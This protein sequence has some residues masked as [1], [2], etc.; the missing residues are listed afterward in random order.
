MQQLTER[1]SEARL[2]LAPGRASRLAGRT[3]LWAFLLA[4][5]GAVLFPV[6]VALLGSF[7]TNA[8]LIAGGTFLPSEWQFANY[9][10]AWREANFARYT[11]NSLFV[12]AAT[13]ALTL[14]I[15]SMAA[16]AIDRLH[17]PGKKWFVAIQGFTMFV[18]IGAVVLR[19]QFE[20]MVSMKLHTSLWGVVFILVSAHASL[21]FIL[22]SYMKSIPR[23]LDEAATIDGAGFWRTYRSVILPLLLPGLGVAGLFTFRAA[24]NEFILPQVFTMNAPQLQTLTVG[25]AALRYG[26]SAAMQTHI[27]LA[28]ACLSIL[29][30]L[31]VYALTNKTF[32]QVTAG[33]LKG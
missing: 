5:A 3:A 4:V 30:M 6:V 1:K 33:S 15:A 17:F 25:L 18:S 31:A 11:W 7:K 9:A 21:F 8:E 10:Y 20:L 16:C 2:R 24:W 22:L 26:S 23:D 13:T 28:G 12:A 19:P 29:P 27:M 32:M 14:L